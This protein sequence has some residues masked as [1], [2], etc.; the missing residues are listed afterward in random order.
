M[1]NKILLAFFAAITIG[2]SAS[3]Q[4]VDELIDKNIAAHGGAEKLRAVKSIRVTGSMLMGPMVAPFTLTKGRPQSFRM[5][6]TIQGMTAIQSYD[7][8]TG[9]MVMPFMG[10]TDPEKMSGEMLKQATEDADFDGPLFDYKAKGNKLELLGKADVDGKPAYKLKLTTKDSAER[11]VYLDA[12]SYLEVREEAKRTIQGQEIESETNL[13]D[14]KAT[15]GLLFATK[16]ESH[17][18]GSPAS[19]TITIDKVELNPTLPADYFA[20]PAAK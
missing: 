12:G 13:G 6:F 8:S 14:Y 4:N 11:I 15:D 20:M 10:K 9:W 17:A 3:A 5:E 7:G 1:T 16:I 18:K 2:A 19:Q